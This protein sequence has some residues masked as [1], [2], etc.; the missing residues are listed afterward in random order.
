MQDKTSPT[1]AIEMVT[2]YST[3]GDAGGYDISVYLENFA[4]DTGDFITFDADMTTGTIDFCVRATS[5]EE[6]IAVVVRDTNFSLEFD[7]S[8][9]EFSLVD[10]SIGELG[11]DDIVTDIDTGFTVE[12]CQCETY[13]CSGDPGTIE[14]N[15]PFVMC[16][17]PFHDSIQA[18]LTVFISNFDL[19]IS[20]GEDA[21]Y[22]EYDPVEFG[23]EGWDPNSLTK[24]TEDSSFPGVLM[25]STPIIATFYS[26][27]FSTVNAGG[28]AFLEF[29]SGAGRLDEIV[30]Y[31]MPFIIDEGPQSG[32]LA[33]L[34][35]GLGGFF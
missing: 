27:G 26:M 35:R 1:A 21:T 19:K 2:E 15:D 29:V 25:I 24:V 4:T 6:D 17:Y 22:T 18:D 13:E 7:V 33:M 14:Q 11:Q 20:A 32:C 12:A 9:V 28:S 16:I 23:S 30:D 31:E 10:V 34:F 3:P 5:Y 8:D